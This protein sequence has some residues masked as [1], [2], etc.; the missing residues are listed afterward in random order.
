MGIACPINASVNI[1]ST[2]NIMNVSDSSSIENISSPKKLEE[3]SDCT[4]DEFEAIFSKLETIIA[5]EQQ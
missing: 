4:D 5:Q 1:I 3:I 2:G